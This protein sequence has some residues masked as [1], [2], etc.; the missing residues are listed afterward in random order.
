MISLIKTSKPKVLE[1]KEHDWTNE[2]LSFL[3]S[4]EKVPNH[5]K[6][7]Y[8]HGEIKDA[9][10]TETNSKCAYCESKITHIDHG[11]IEHILPKS[12]FPEKTFLWDNLTIGCAICNQ[13]KSNYYDD[14]LRLLNPYA[15]FPEDKLIFMGAISFAR[16]GCESAY[17]TIKKLKLNRPELIERRGDL[18][19]KIQ[20]LIWEYEKTENEELRRLLLQELIEFTNKDQEY[21]LMIKQLLDSLSITA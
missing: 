2:L 12:I 21:S 15:D 13:S 5:I 10:L 8:R 16:P 7:R 17:F 1:D 3:N 19:K 18:I 20:P 6:A 11:D 4:D 9:L 14:S